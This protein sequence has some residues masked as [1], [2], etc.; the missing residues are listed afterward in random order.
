M[1]VFAGA[2]ATMPMESHQAMQNHTLAPS[3]AMCE[4]CAGGFWPRGFHRI[5]SIR[6][7]SRFLSV[8]LLFGAPVP[9]ARGDW[10]FVIMGDTRGPHDTTTGVSPYLNTLATKI[11]DLHP[12]LV[13]VSGDLCNGNATNGLTAL[14]YAEQFANWKTAMTPVSTL[15][16]PIYPVRGN[17]DNN[18]SEG[19]P[20][21]ELKQAYYD[22]FGAF[23]PANG[24]NN[25]PGDDQ[26]GFT[27]SFAHN[28]ATFIALD[29]YFYYNQTP[30]GGYHR[31]DLAW[32]DQQLQLAN[33]PHTVVLGHV[34]VFMATGQDTPE[35]FFGT[36]AAGYQMRTDFWNSLGS[37]GARLYIGGHIHNLAVSSAPDDSGNVIYQMTAGHGGAPLNAIQ[38][39]HDPQVSLLYTNDTHYGFALATVGAEAMTIDYYLLNPSNETWS[40]AVYTTTINAVPEPSS[41]ALVAAGVLALMIRRRT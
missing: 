29:Q 36:D 3:G 41:C 8:L 20:I 34:P 40:K 39:G 15:G 4:H 19:A 16:I 25:G 18:A 37:N 14:T 30:Q 26:R 21:A 38:P 1:L 7:R 9:G 24:P 10:S 23:M 33:T 5:A 31:L 17:H 35:H 28:N 13:L 6:L 32:L 22:A 2:A 12:D 27:Y 11:A